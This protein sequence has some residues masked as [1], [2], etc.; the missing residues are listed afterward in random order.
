MPR[1]KKMS[2]A[3]TAK[4]AEEHWGQIVSIWLTCRNALPRELMELIRHFHTQFYNMAEKY[5]LQPGHVAVAMSHVLAP[6][7]ATHEERRP[8]HADPDDWTR[9]I[10]AAITD[11]IIVAHALLK[12][13]DEGRIIADEATEQ[14]IRRPLH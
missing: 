7:V 8:E 14:L 5:G 13:V 6:V 10:Y 1:R 4:A 3:E 9:A 12:A 2:E 11:A